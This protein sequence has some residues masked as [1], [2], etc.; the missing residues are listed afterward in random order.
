M[1]YGPENF[2]DDSIGYLLKRQGVIVEQKPYPPKV[3]DIIDAVSLVSKVHRR[4]IIG[5]YRAEDYLLP[6]RCVYWIAR[7]FTL[8][9]YP[10]IGRAIGMRDHTTIISGV[11]RVNKY[12]RIHRPI[13]ENAIKILENR[14]FYMMGEVKF[15]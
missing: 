8:L 10:Q 13:I 9:S 3:S 6:R 2:Y 11:K 1:I 4:D 5:P 15:G 14:G 7:H 12:T